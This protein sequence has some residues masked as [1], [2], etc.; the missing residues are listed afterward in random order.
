MRIAI[1]GATGLLGRNL[2][3]EIL[4]QNLKN[5]DNLKIF[6]FGRPKDN[7]SHPERILN[8]ISS[9]GL[10]YIG[11]SKN[12]I[13]QLLKAIVTISFDLEIEQLNISKDDFKS[14]SN[15]NIDYFFH[16]AAYTDFRSSPAIYDTLREINVNGTKRICS[17][18]N[19]LQVKEFVYIGSAYSCGNKTGLINPDYIDKSGA[20]RNPYENSK[21]EAE[22]YFRDF[23][24]MNKINYKVFR[25]TTISGRLIEKPLGR[26][27]KYDV[28]YSWIAFFIRQKMKYLKPSDDIY[29]TPFEMPIR[30]HFNPKGGLN[31]VPVDY[32]AKAIYDI[33]TSNEPNN[34]YHLAN[35]SITPNQMYGDLTFKTLNIS[36]YKY[37]LK[38]P[39][40]KNA[41]ETLYYRTVG[42][43]FT[44]YGV[45]DPI[46]FNTDCLRNF[47]K[48]TGINCPVV[49]EK[50][51]AILLEYAKKDNFGIPLEKAG[52]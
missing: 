19:S 52:K 3:F 33:C 39:I 26:I 41:F 10:D 30:L 37:V 35:D 18:V 46:I 45:S 11:I 22:I 34:N 4:K 49:D 40:D 27:N 48:R 14:L 43:L 1:T 29:K 36:K 8:I 5:L 21:L 38:E 16:V 51:L 47:N 28:F 13:Q 7:L 9:D 12:N 24:K 20:F 25:P 6:V 50:N 31:I 32:C 23:V 15:N 44:P 2:L 17:L 42:K